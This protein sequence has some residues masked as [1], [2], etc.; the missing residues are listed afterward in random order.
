MREKKSFAGQ[1]WIAIHPRYPINV[2]T[3]FRISAIYS[4][5][6][7]SGV[8]SM[9]LTLRKRRHERSTAHHLP[10]FPHSIFIPTTISTYIG[11]DN[12]AVVPQYKLPLPL[13][14]R[15]SPPLP[16]MA[17]FTASCALFLAAA[18]A[19]ANAAEYRVR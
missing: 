6:V 18:L 4:S 16:I 12:K 11:A 1:R 19:L 14:R 5:L 3:R 10:H 15:P 7:A 2:A 8:W 17:R 13:R 9:R